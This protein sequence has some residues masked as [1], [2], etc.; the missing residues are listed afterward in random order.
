MLKKAFSILLAVVLQCLLPF[1]HADSADTHADNHAHAVAADSGFEV[2]TKILYTGENTGGSILPHFLGNPGFGGEISMHLS[3]TTDFS[4]SFRSVQSNI[5]DG[6]SG[7]TGHTGISVGVGQKVGIAYLSARQ[8]YMHTATDSTDFFQHDMYE[9]ILKAELADSAQKPY[10]FAGLIMPAYTPP[11]EI[12]GMGGFGLTTHV[13]V[14]N[15]AGWKTGIHAD[16]SIATSLLN[17]NH[18]SETVMRSRAALQ[19]Q[20]KSAPLEISLGFNLYQD[21]QR[22]EHNIWWDLSLSYLF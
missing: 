8:S 18:E 20:S 7:L 2:Q 15:G 21:I 13:P 11:E 22:E 9:T 5:Q 3:G 12:L 1:A 4:G 6:Q 14:H 19:T 16:V 17:I 10:L